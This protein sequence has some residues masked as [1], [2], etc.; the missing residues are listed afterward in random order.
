MIT[1]LDKTRTVHIFSDM[2]GHQLSPMLDPSSSTT[3][4]DGGKP[5][6]RDHDASL[7]RNLT[8]YADNTL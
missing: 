3:T 5:S 8:R 2:K 7:N 1:R 6:H 4:V